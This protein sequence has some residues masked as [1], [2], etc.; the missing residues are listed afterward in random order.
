M[1]E[2]YP[3]QLLYLKGSRSMVAVNE[4]DISLTSERALIV[5]LN[6]GWEWLGLSGRS[7][8][9]SHGCL[10]WH[11]A[12]G[13]QRNVSCVLVVLPGRRNSSNRSINQYSNLK[14]GGSFETFLPHRKY[15][16]RSS[17]INEINIRLFSQTAWN[18]AMLGT[19]AHYGSTYIWRSNRSLCNIARNIGMV[20]LFRCFVP[21]ALI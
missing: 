2:Y 1:D 16:D 12:C 11:E 10:W 6:Q 15:C 5:G 21:R 20:Q 19:E 7:D 3:V 13:A 14:T 4:T 9:S 8:T 18:A 17:E